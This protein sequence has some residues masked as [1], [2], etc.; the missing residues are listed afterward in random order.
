MKKIYT[1]NEIKDKINSGDSIKYTEIEKMLHHL[2]M[3]YTC[4]EWERDVARKEAEKIR[5]I[6]RAI[7]I[8][9]WEEGSE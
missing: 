8:F 7:S 6:K 4:L 2:M 9:P 3:R 5:G 1:Y